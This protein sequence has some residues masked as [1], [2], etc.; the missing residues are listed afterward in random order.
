ML[1]T[2]SPEMTLCVTPK[3]SN[4]RE[5]RSRND[6]SSEKD[7][8]S[9]PSVLPPN[10]KISRLESPIP[11][12]LCTD[13]GDN[14]DIYNIIGGEDDYYDIDNNNNNDTTFLKEDDSESLSIDCSTNDKNS[15]HN[16]ERKLTEKMEESNNKD[17]N[18][19]DDDD[20]KNDVSDII[21]YNQDFSFPHKEEKIVFEE[22]LILKIEEDNDVTIDIHLQEEN[23]HHQKK[24]KLVEISGPLTVNNN[25]INDEINQLKS[26]LKFA[27]FE[28]LN[29]KD[30]LNDSN[31]DRDEAIAKYRDIVDSLELSNAEITSKKIIIDT[32]NK[33]NENLRDEL[34]LSNRQISI[35]ELKINEL[36]QSNLF[37]E[38]QL[39]DTWQKM[40]VMSEAVTSSQQE[41]LLEKNISEK[42]KNEINK[43]S[44]KLS[45]LQQDYEEI[46]SKL[47][48][49]QDILDNTK[50]SV[51]EFEKKYWNCSDINKQNETKNKILIEELNSKII[52]LSNNHLFDLNKIKLLNNHLEEKNLELKI[53]SNEIIKIS[54]NNINLNNEIQEKTNIINKQENDLIDKNYQIEEKN[55]YIKDIKNE[56]EE[57]KQNIIELNNLAEELNEQRLNITVKLENSETTIM[58]LES[59]IEEKELNLEKHKELI[60][61]INK[62]SGDADNTKDKTRRI[63]DVSSKFLNK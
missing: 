48:S 37:N 27:E 32:C 31:Q 20:Y 25:D 29:L 57:K 41:V 14:N 9:T 17:K 46:Q 34:L 43:K 1:G 10:K 59:K 52:Q 8:S 6:S 36:K 30:N 2:A 5:M 3:L 18:N 44:I 23:Q 45:L 55:N 50:N 13:D 7:S 62:L 60:S 24:E 21:K 16:Q 33:E 54:D 42:L 40:T 51:K 49:N 61:F 28:I 63:S 47:K 15:F 53:K 38:N 56:L 19:D 35:A 58:E 26:K 39:R 12:N 4:S 11:Y 22:T